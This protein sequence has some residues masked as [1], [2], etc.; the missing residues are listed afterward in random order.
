MNW[1]GGEA[2]AWK[3]VSNMPILMLKMAQ[4]LAALG[5]DIW[6]IPAPVYRFVSNSG[7]VFYIPN[8]GNLLKDNRIRPDNGIRRVLCRHLQM[9]VSRVPHLY[10]WWPQKHLTT[11]CTKTRSS[12][13]LMSL[14]ENLSGCFSLE[15]VDQRWGWLGYWPMLWRIRG[16]KI[17]CRNR[18]RNLNE[19]TCNWEVVE[20]FDPTT[21]AILQK[22]GRFPWGEDLFWVE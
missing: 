4:I 8:L 16:D 10:Q 22:R 12:R 17:F 5:K 9:M 20:D 6:L 18:F 15:F 2:S 1:P 7:A 19:E 11:W 13:I 14:T 3:L 21:D